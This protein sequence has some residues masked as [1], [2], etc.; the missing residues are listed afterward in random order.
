MSGSFQTVIEE[1]TELPDHLSWVE[2]GI[3]KEARR[4]KI[5]KRRRNNSV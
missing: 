3:K 1:G 4:G 5:S 2:E